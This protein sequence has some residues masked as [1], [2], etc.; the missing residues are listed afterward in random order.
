MDSQDLKKI[1]TGISIAGLLSIGTLT[2]S[3]CATTPES[4]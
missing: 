2:L 1:L 3:G 4:S